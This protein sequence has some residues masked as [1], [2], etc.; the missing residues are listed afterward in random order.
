MPRA[1][2]SRLAALAGV[3]QNRLPAQEAWAAPW[4]EGPRLC[5][6]HRDAR[7]GDLFVAVRGGTFD[8][9]SAVEELRAR[10][11]RCVIQQGGAATEGE[12]VVADSRSWLARAAELLA[13]EA[14]SS[15][16]LFAITGTNGKTTTAWIL[17]HLLLEKDPQ[18]GLCGTLG[19]K[20]GREPLLAGSLTTPPAWELS[21]FCAAVR[22]RGG[23]SLVLEASSHAID[24]RRLQGL[25]FHAAAFLNLA[26]EHL[27]Y[28]HSMEEYFRC[29]ASFLQREDLVLR[30]VLC[31]DEWGRRLAGQLASRCITAGSGEDCRWRLLERLPRGWSQRLRL[32]SPQG[33]ESYDLP[34]PGSYNANNALA[35]IVLARESGLTEEEVRQGLAGLPA[36]PGR[37]ESLQAPGRPRVVIDYAHTPDGYRACLQSLR[38][39]HTGPLTCVFGCGGERDRAKR[40]EMVRAA[41]A[42]ADRLVLCLDNP[43]RED[44]EQIFGDMQAGLDASMDHRRIDDRR[45]A[46]RWAVEH[47]PGKGLV[48]LLGK[49]HERYQLIG[50]ERLPFD[51]PAIVR[52]LLDG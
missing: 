13:G 2:A 7:P 38:E 8:G 6:D 33:E 34:L 21:R 29:K 43:R 25:S 22:Q 24:Q 39:W 20:H 14:A 51:E 27:D 42:F 9:H 15:L 30:L 32:G 18:A 44:P 35:A 1:T 12:L 11:V 17:Q 48:L 5:S 36:V 10:G 46:I 37:M 19:M 40:P 23:R 52:E 3:I 45:E 26:P 4:E 31:E 16:R 50:G 47:T 28:H 41:G 49:G